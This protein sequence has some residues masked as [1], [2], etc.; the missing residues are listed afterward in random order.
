[1]AREADRTKS[2][3]AEQLGVFESAVDQEGSIVVLIALDLNEE[4]DT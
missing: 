1:V 2:R 3:D 4:A